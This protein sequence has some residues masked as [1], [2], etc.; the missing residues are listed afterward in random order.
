MHY[1]LIVSLIWSL[2]FGMIGATFA[3][4]NSDLLAGLRLAI[5]LPVFLPLLRWHGLSARHITALL[6]IGAI[7]Y[8]LMYS[9]LFRAFAYLQGHEVAILTVV[10][11][12]W[13][14]LFH[15]LWERN[16]RWLY[17][18]VALLALL[19][20]LWVEQPQAWSAPIQG[21]ILMQLSNAAFAL[22]QVWYVQLRRKQLP[23]HADHILYAL[24]FVGGAVCC[25]L[26]ATFSGGWSDLPELSATQWTAL[27][28]LGIVASGLGFFGW[29]KG[30]TM[31]NAGQLAVWN[32][33][34]IPLAV[35]V[36]VVVFDESTSIPAL[37]I[38]GALILVSLLLAKRGA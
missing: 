38:G 13:V 37:I 33:L 10:T 23:D 8:G 29:N 5:A 6:A 4:I 19:G 34:K 24:P 17:L 18:G 1:L 30:A 20:G 35:T 12:L 26:A 2:S 15:S 11:P 25:L 21:I 3:G 31:V 36:S 27:I 28:Y 9:L 7:Q 32:N 16:L 14:V 22:G